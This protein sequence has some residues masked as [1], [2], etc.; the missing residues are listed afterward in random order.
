MMRTFLPLNIFLSVFFFQTLSAQELPPARPN[1]VLILADDLGKYDLSVY[2]GRNIE[3]PHIDSLA[4]SGALFSQG[5]AMAAVCSPSRMALLSGQYHQ[6]WGYDFQPHQRYPR[7]G[8][9]RWFAHRLMA[10]DGWIPAIQERVPPKKEVRGHG[11]PDEAFTLGER[12]REQG[13]RSGLFGK[14]H[15]GYDAQH[16]PLRH[17]FDVFYGF[18]EAYSLFAPK[19]DRKVVNAPVPLF[20][21]KVQWKKRKGATA[22]LRGET[23][24]KEPRY[25]TDAIAEEAMTFMQPQGGQP[26]FAMLSFS[27]PH[28]PWQAPRE[29]YDQLGHIPDHHRRVYYGMVMALDQAV[30]RVMAHLREQGLLEN[31]IVIFTS[32]NGI[33]AYNG[34]LDPAPHKGAKASLFEGG[35]N[36]PLC[37]SWP[38]VVSAGRTLNAPVSHLDLGAT[39][40][41][42]AGADPDDRLDGRNLLPALAADARPLPAQTLYWRAGY[43]KALRNERYKALIDEKQKLIFLYDLAADPAEQHNLA[44]RHAGLVEALRR[45]LLQWE[46]AMRPPAWPHVIDYR[47]VIEGEVYFFGI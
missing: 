12:L 25:F 37:I 35:I 40:A 18:L 38:G 7:N 23:D 16:H 10:R 44:E 26:F 30:G 19:N 11:I 22:I 41:A 4:R 27:A 29:V 6:R 39:I 13:Y 3:T 1:I 2:G 33:A 42:A 36:V 24:V 17:G 15:L 34:H 43:N 46:H 20:A 9:Q 8:F 31:T 47:V 14:W 21:D 28:A 45:D 5:Y 32:D